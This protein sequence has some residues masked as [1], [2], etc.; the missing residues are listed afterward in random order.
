MRR[1]RGSSVGVGGG[2]GV[3]GSVGVGVGVGGS[4]GNSVGIAFASLLRCLATLLVLQ[5]LRRAG[6][7]GRA[8]QHR[9]LS[10]QTSLSTDLSQHRPLS[11]Q[12]H[13]QAARRRGW[14]ARVFEGAAA[15][16]SGGCRRQ[17]ERAHVRL[18]RSRWV[19]ALGP[20]ILELASQLCEH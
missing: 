2:G 17:A 19:P 1:G 5:M 16:Q 18:D 10:A 9:P 4:V 3:G 7:T 20:L 12:A 6:A 11:A 8:S 15:H 13:A 14:H